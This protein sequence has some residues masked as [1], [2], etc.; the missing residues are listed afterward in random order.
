MMIK[1]VGTLA[2]EPIS[3]MFMVLRRYQNLSN[4]FPKLSES[5]FYKEIRKLSK[6]YRVKSFRLAV[7]RGI[8]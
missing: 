5:V 7:L 6:T 3:L 8:S 1:G 2:R 4:L